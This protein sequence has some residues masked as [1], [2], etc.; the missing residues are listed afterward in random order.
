MSQPIPWTAIVNLILALSREAMDW[1]NLVENPGNQGPEK[2]KLR[3]TTALIIDPDT[4]HETVEDVIKDE[5][6]PEIT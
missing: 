6:H 3:K 2:R 5:D 4:K 1:F